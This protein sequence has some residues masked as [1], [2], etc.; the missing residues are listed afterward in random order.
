MRDLFQSPRLP[1]RR[2]WESGSYRPGLEDAG[3]SVPVF[4]PI[5]PNP[6]EFG[7][8]RLAPR[9]RP[10]QVQV[11]AGGCRWRQVSGELPV[12]SLESN[13][14]QGKGDHP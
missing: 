7:A 1:L 10:A 12:S 4:I 14:R 9:L 2:T 3:I 6:G 5:S 11:S 13:I 8:L